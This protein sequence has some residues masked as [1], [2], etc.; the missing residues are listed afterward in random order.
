[1]RTP[2]QQQSYITNNFCISRLTC[3]FYSALFANSS[4]IQRQHYSKYVAAVKSSK[5]GSH[6]SDNLWSENILSVW[7]SLT[8]GL[9]SGIFN[10]DSVANEGSDQEQSL[11]NRKLFLLTSHQLS[12]ASQHCGKTFITLVNWEHVD[13]K[14]LFL[15]KCNITKLNYE[16]YLIATKLF[17][18]KIVWLSRAVFSRIKI[19]W[20]QVWFSVMKS[21]TCCLVIGQRVCWSRDESHIVDAH[22]CMISQ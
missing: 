10:V 16:Q 11:S 2:W 18:F 22:T 15:T 17:D 7:A 3:A 9:F 12:V 19:V 4:N 14:L 13:G 20:H 8:Y 1:M 5:H 6:V 21:L